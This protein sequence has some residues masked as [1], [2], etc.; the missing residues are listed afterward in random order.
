MTI[1][2]TYIS[3]ITYHDIISISLALVIVV[4]YMFIVRRLV[5]R[6]RQLRGCVACVGHLTIIQDR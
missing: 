3:Y 2:Y 5:D 1:Y 6:Q 4:Y